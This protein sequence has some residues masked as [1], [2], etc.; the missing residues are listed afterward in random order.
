MYKM[1]HSKK[2]AVVSVPGKKETF[3]PLTLVSKTEQVDKDLRD[4]TK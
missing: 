2:V 4:K 1:H 3:L